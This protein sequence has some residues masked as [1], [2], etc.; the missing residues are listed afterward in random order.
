MKIGALFSKKIRKGLIG[1]KES[2]EKI[3]K[4]QSE[5]KPII[6]M[7][8][9]SMGEYLQGLPVLEELKKKHPSHNILITFFSPSGYEYAIKKDQI[10]DFIAYLPFDTPKNIKNFTKNLKIDYFLIIKYDF[11]YFLLKNLKNKN[12]KTFIISAHFYKNQFFFKPWGKWAK[13]QLK[14]NIDWIFH[15]TENSLLLC[16]KIG[17]KNGSL[18][19]DTRF[20]KVKQNQK[21][22]TELIDIENFT[23][24]KTTIILGSS[25][26]DE[27]NIAQ[28]IAEKIDEKTCIIIAPHDLNRVSI[29]QQ[30]IPK[31]LFFSQ[32]KN[33]KKFDEKVLIIDNIGLLSSIYAYGN[34][35]IIGGGFHSK[36][37]HNTLEAATFGLALIF[38]NRYK[39][40]PEADELIAHHAA[41]SFSTPKEASDFVLNLI[42]NPILT[43]NMG[44]NAQ[45]FIQKQPNATQIII[46]HILSEK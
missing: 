24:N 34:I 14:K 4:I 38:G 33:E 31:S 18:S 35:A 28:N 37:L 27:E 42:Q 7:H 30:K 17:L 6:W 44:K 10:A 2:I 5:N 41:K 19:G 8:S 12:T 23:K 13:N 3:K 46:N 25:W 1:R 16:Q 11:W 21:E 36:G 45:N 15:Q 20:D 39:K 32:L 9:A 29:I 43:Q 26:Q 22:K 40:N